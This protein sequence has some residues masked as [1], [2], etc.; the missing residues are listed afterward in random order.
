M[1]RLYALIRQIDLARD[2]KNPPPT[3]SRIVDL[4]LIVGLCGLVMGV[5]EWFVRLQEH[6][7]VFLP[8][9]GPIARHSS[10]PALEMPWPSS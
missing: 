10:K 3:K 1:G 9:F 5:Y 7:S 8:M 2:M 6:R 4:L